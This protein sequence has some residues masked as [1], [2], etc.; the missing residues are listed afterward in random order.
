[1]K[2]KD[3]NRRSGSAP[4]VLYQA[5]IK[6]QPA[7]FK[8]EL[9]RQAEKCRFPRKA[10]IDLVRLEFGWRVVGQPWGQGV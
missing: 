4:F 2:R 10:S 9:S 3:I 6:P 7:A 1:M 5:T 8:H